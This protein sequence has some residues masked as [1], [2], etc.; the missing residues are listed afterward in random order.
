MLRFH[1]VSGAV[2]GGHKHRKHHLSDHKLVSNCTLVRTVSG[3]GLLLFIYE[4]LVLESD[5]GNWCLLNIERDLM[6]VSCSS[7]NCPPS[8]VGLLLFL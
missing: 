4:F 5:I 8:L 3:L 2:G 7:P 6:V 1:C